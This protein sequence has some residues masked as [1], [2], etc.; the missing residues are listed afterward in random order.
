MN[1]LMERLAAANPMP[2]D[3]PP[4]AAEQ[5]NVDA[6]LERILATPQAPAAPRRSLVRRVTPAAALLA[7]VVVAVVVVIDLVGSEED[8]GGIVDRALAA[9]SQEDVIYAV[10]ERRTS[11][12]SP[13][14]PGLEVS[15]DERGYVRYW[16]W[17]GDERS[18]FLMYDMRADGSRGRLESEVTAHDRRLTWFMARSNTISVRE[19]PRQDRDDEPARGGFPG[20]SPFAE[21]GAQLRAEVDE[22]RL[23]VGGRT[24]VRGRRA[25]R[26]VSERRS[27]P[28]FED[29][30]VT[31][32]VDARTYLPLELRVRIVFKQSR[33]EPGGGGREL[34]R[35]RIEYL[36]YEALPV[37]DENK[38]LLEMGEHP[39][40]RVMGRP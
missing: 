27:G 3:E 6:L 9:V 18:R 30:R 8:G 36:R 28:G 35:L 13:L 4:T 38:A 26:L 25:Y 23:R 32:L 24:T 39:G 20:F 10:T 17:A 33:F 19:P 14:T 34:A 21:P 29:E 40:A 37:T 7:A 31:Y 22:G 5:R 11:T 16:L 12:S 15:P 1:E 2:A